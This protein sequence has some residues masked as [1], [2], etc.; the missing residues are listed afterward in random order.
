MCNCTV[1]NIQSVSIKPAAAAAENKQLIVINS[2]SFGIWFKGKK[3][4][5]LTTLRT[6]NYT[7]ITGLK[8]SEHHLIYTL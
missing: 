4:T 1:I 8:S 6:E 3:N 7:S 5:C 2:S